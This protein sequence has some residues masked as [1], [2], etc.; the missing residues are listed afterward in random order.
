VRLTGAIPGVLWERPIEMQR[1]YHSALAAKPGKGEMVRRVKKGKSEQKV[2]RVMMGVTR[3]QAP[4]VPLGRTAD[5]L[6]KIGRRLI[7]RTENQDV[8][9]VVM[10]VT[11]SQTPRVPLGRRAKTGSRLSDRRE[12]PKVRR[13]VMRVTPSQAPK[14]PPGN[15]GAGKVQNYRTTTTSITTTCHCERKWNPNTSPQRLPKM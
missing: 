15:R 4:R 14:V 2:W 6:A 11:P 5:T 8:R 12:N 7:N 9:Q 13:V 3:S 10:G 1:E